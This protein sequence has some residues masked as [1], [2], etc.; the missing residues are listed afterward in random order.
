MAKTVTVPFDEV[1]EE[2][3]LVEALD[4]TV[5]CARAVD[6]W[7]HYLP[8]GPIESVEDFAALPLA[9]RA[10]LSM[11]SR[12]NELIIDPRWVFRSTYPYYQNVCTF[13]FQMVAGEMDL[14]IRHERMQAILE[15]VGFEEGGESLI[16]A[17]PPQFFFASDLCAEIFFEGHH[18]S[19]Q[20][21]T[22]MSE[23]DIA[24]RI[25]DFN[26]EMII[27]A[28]D[29]RQITPAAIPDSV[30]GILTF[31][32]DFPELTE[33]KAKVIDIYTLTEFPYLGWREGGEKFYHYT[34]DHHYVERSPNG[35]V[36]VTNLL[37]E[38]M[39]LI[40]YQTF[41][42]IGELDDENGLLEV[43]SYG[44]W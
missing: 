24:K 29:S 36:T 23:Q 43:T 4:S 28:T 9:S 27:V 13:P 21:I 8:D 15:A 37:W 33:T 20:D 11:A 12:L 34:P 35:L 40:R 42:T 38:L 6:F 25:E 32:G 41:D 5:R 14:Y 44:E 16:L 2:Q 18:C 22:G 39:P 30:K 7:K 19:I 31:R 26:A 17:S 10:E 3:T 1:H